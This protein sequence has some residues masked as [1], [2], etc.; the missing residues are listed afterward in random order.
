MKT[1][2]WSILIRQDWGRYY[3]LYLQSPEWKAIRE[4]VFQ[5]DVMCLCGDY[6]NRNTAQV[7]H[8]TY[9]CVGE[10]KLHQLIALCKSCHKLFHNKRR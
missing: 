5:R 9:E 10:E 6:L 3:P 8:K 4:Q 2:D 7:H 1:K